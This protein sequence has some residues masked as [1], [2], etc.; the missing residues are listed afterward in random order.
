[1]SQERL[2]QVFATLDCCLLQY[3]GENSPWTSATNEAVV[4]QLEMVVKLQNAQIQRL[5]D[6]LV[7]RYGFVPRVNYPA[8][9][10]DL[11]YLSLGY[12]IVRLIADQKAVLR[13]IESE[14]KAISNDPGATDLLSQL[15]VGIA[16]TI[17]SLKEIENQLNAEQTSSTAAD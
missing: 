9:Y 2:N 17:Q 11:Q 10:T 6:F 8:D 1:M 3:I 7:N 12:L 4:E 14:R 16:K 15:E 5:A 13:L